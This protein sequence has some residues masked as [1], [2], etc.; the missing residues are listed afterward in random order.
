MKSAM[1][2]KSVI[3]FPI[4]IVDLLNPAKSNP[5]RGVRRAWTESLSGIQIL[6]GG[7]VRLPEQ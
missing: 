7:H 3:T 1:R 6:F 4:W 5:C 2:W